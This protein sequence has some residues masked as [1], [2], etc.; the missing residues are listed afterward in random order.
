MLYYEVP[1]VV[2]V[3]VRTHGVVPVAPDALLYIYIYIYRERE[4]CIYIY[5]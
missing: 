1:Q 2:L 3:Q 5:I 4:R